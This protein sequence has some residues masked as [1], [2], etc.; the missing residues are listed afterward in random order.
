VTSPLDEVETDGL[1]ELFNLAVGKAAASL[2]RL[3]SHEISISVPAVALVPVDMAAEM[4]PKDDG[5]GLVAVHSAF[6]GGLEGAVALVLPARAGRE[7]VGLALHDESVSDPADFEQDAL[8]EIGNVVVNACLAGLAQAFGR[9]IATAV[10]V[11]SRGARAAVMASLAPAARGQ[12]LLLTIDFGVR[13]RRI[14]GYLAFVLGED[15]IAVFRAALRSYI[16]RIL[17]GG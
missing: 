5:E 8:Q 16:E 15:G 1:A 14:E 3:V 7:L 12:V 2:A 11:V 13:A 17:A 10:P 6:S 4:L 9:E